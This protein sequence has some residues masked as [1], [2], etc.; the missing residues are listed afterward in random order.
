M[1]SNQYTTTTIR[2]SRGRLV[3]EQNGIVDDREGSYQELT[4]LTTATILNSVGVSDV[5]HDEIRMSLD[6]DG[7]IRTSN[8]IDE[9]LTFPGEDGE[10]YVFVNSGDQEVVVIVIKDGKVHIDE[11]P[12]VR[13]S[14]Q[15]QE[16]GVTSLEYTAV[17]YTVNCDRQCTI[18]SA[19]ANIIGERL[20]PTTTDST[21]FVEM[22]YV[23]LRQLLY[24]DIDSFSKLLGKLNRQ[25]DRNDLINLWNQFITRSSTVKHFASRRYVSV[26]TGLPIYGSYDILDNKPLVVTDPSMYYNQNYGQTYGP[27]KLTQRHLVEEQGIH[28]INPRL[29]SDPSRGILRYDSSFSVTGIDCRSLVSGYQSLQQ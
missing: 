3:D 18:P 11:V 14:R 4:V 20:G 10:R 22:S 9:T 16:V 1:D 2:R 19:L 6:R 15:L 13:P 25:L 12:L 21:Y 28:T 29:F 7:P 23:T 24:L 17:Q 26:R 8:V 5:H 27:G